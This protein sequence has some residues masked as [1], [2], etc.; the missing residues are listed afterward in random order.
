[1]LYWETACH[2]T[3]A[4][5][6]VCI[7]A[8]L[9]ISSTRLLR[10]RLQAEQRISCFKPHRRKKAGERGRERVWKIKLAPKDN[11][12]TNVSEEGK[13]RVSRWCTG[14]TP[15]LP[16][17]RS[18]IMPRNAAWGCTVGNCCPASQILVI[19]FNVSFYGLK[20]YWRRRKD[21]VYFTVSLLC[22]LVPGKKR[23]EINISSV[24]FTECFLSISFCPD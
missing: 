5:A 24:F 1:M 22:S 7:C 6:C 11:Y 9:L 13:P 15:M 20:I 16:S 18:V 19:T 2:S 23:E 10:V 4:C 8:Y 21:T 17:P 12:W 14:Y 3:R